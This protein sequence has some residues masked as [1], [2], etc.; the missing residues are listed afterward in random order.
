[1]TNGN[2]ILEYEE[3]NIESLTASFCQVYEDEWDTY[4]AE[5]HEEMSLEEEM[6]DFA[7]SHEDWTDFV[8]HQYATRGV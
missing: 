2:D 7:T 8:E 5:F 6:I 1:M 4:N 3:D